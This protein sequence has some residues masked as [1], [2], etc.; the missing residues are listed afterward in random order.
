MEKLDE[1]WSYFIGFAQCDGSLYK[2]KNSNKGRFSIELKEEDSELLYE[3]KNMIPYNSS[4]RFRTRDTNFK[5]GAKSC[6]FSVC[7]IE[8]R[9]KINKIGIPYGKKSDI[10]YKPEDVIDCDYFRGIIDADGSLGF[11]KV[12]FPFLSFCTKSEKLAYDFLEFLNKIT[13]KEKILNRNKRDNIFNI[14]IYKEDAVN[15]I[16][17]LYYDGS[18]NLN[19]KYELAKDIIKWKRPSDMKLRDF[20]V[21]K[22]AKEEDEFIL[23]NTIDISIEVLNRTEKS[24]KT[25]LWRLKKS[26][27]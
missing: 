26:N 14:T 25:R 2:S 8:F 21:K 9:N 5:N 19:R 12:G 24:I 13:N 10:V 16:E 6:I 3:F 20:S 15:I 22:W 27:A 17:Y 18:I 7:D 23:N 4:I 1:K 11:T